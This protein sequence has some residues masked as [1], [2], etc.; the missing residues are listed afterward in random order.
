MEIQQ[1][2]AEEKST[3]RKLNEALRRTR[4]WLGN[5]ISF[6]H[7]MAVGKASKV[8]SVSISHKKATS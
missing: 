3:V 6:M 8:E 4:W 5:L 2:I 1:I 7:L